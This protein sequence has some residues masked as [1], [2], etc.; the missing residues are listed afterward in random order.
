VRLMTRQRVRS[1][2]GVLCVLL[3]G[4][5]LPASTAL[6][7]L[8]GVAAAIGVAANERVADWLPRVAIERGEGDSLGVVRIRRAERWGRRRLRRQTE[9][10]VNDWHRYRANTASHPDDFAEFANVINSAAPEDRDVAYEKALPLLQLRD[11][12]RRIRVELAFKKR[13]GTLESEYQRRG[14]LA[15]TTQ[16]P[17]EPPPEASDVVIRFGGPVGDAVRRL[18]ELVGDL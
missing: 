18:D 16:F 13:I 5:L 3:A 10:V 17:E 11:A 15:A 6:W 2:A 4:V 14:L 9:A 7:I 1:A 8:L 12:E